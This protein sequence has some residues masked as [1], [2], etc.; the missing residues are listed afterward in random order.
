MLAKS[1]ETTHVIWECGVSVSTAGQALPATAGLR[2]S[3]STS[4]EEACFELLEIRRVN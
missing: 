2:S 1:F 3:A 4:E